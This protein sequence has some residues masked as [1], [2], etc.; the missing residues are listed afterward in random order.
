MISELSGHLLWGGFFI[1]V[2]GKFE[3][4]HL[5]ASNA[6]FE[7]NNIP[8]FY[9]TD[10]NYAPYLYVSIKSLISHINPCVALLLWH[11]D[12]WVLWI[13]TFFFRVMVSLIILAT[14][15][16]IISLL[17]LVIGDTSG[18]KSYCIWF[19]IVFIC[20]VSSVFISYVLFLLFIFI[21]IL[22]FVFIIFFIVIY[23]F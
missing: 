10:E 22:S 21:V 18:R 1:N 13:D 23:Y 15:T 16:S 9:A 19:N 4:S 5:F 14:F 12:A 20:H 17:L 11:I 3:M 8:V 2:L 7:K 6:A